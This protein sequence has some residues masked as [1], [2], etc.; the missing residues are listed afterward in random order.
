[1]SVARKQHVKRRLTER[2]PGITFADLLCALKTSKLVRK[3][4]VRGMKVYVVVRKGGEIKTV[5]TEE[6]AYEDG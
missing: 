3:D 2:Y 4:T 5:L 6:M 1:M